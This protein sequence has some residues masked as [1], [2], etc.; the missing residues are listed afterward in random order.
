VEGRDPGITFKILSRHLPGGTKENV[1]DPQLG[2]AVSTP[3]FEPGT[4]K[5]EVGMLTT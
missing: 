2:W 5:Y 4:S 1:E 3:R